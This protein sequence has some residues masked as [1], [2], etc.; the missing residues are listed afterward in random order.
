MQLNE[1]VP[2]YLQELPSDPIDEN[3]CVFNDCSLSDLWWYSVDFQGIDAGWDDHRHRD[4]SFMIQRRSVEQPRKRDL[5]QCKILN[6][7]TCPGASHFCA[8]SSRSGGRACCPQ[9]AADC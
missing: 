9:R 7:R 2:K 1:L 3:R 8:R 5:L 4:M 6:S